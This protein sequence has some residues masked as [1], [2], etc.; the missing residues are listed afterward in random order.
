[1]NAKNIKAKQ[2]KKYEFFV[3]YRFVRII[4]F[5]TIRLVI[6]KIFKLWIKN[7][8]GTENIPSKGPEIFVCNHRSYFDFIILGS[9]ILRNIVFLAQRKISQASFIRWLTR[10]HNVIYVDRDYPG[11]AFFK[12]LL[13]YLEEGKLLVI[14][15]EGMRSRTG[16]MLMP[17]LGFVKLAMKAN[18]PIIPVAMKGTYKILPPNKHIPKLKKCKVIV[19]KKMYVSPDNPYFRDVFF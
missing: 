10:F 19:G 12:R 15:P 9:I 2:N 1:M 4:I 14:Y 17:K 13:R 6:S 8:V 11:C 5:K 18:A 7:I 3:L 16:K